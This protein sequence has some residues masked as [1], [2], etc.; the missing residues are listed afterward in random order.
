MCLR[1]SSLPTCTGATALSW[2]GHG[3][4]P[5]VWKNPRHKD[6]QQN[7]QPTFPSCH[8]IPLWSFPV[9]TTSQ[10]PHTSPVSNTFY[11]GYHFSIP[12]TLSHT[13]IHPLHLTQLSV[14]TLSC[15]LHILVCTHP[16]HL[17][18]LPHVFYLQPQPQHNATLSLPHS[19]QH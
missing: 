7:S 8:Y 19:S 6:W 13:H 18:Q 9:S 14:L 2:A 15:C 1:L 17:A 10:I 4:L 3:K 5:E 16:C 11:L 12:Q